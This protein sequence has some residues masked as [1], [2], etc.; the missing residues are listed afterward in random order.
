MVECSTLS[1]IGTFATQLSR[2]KWNFLAQCAPLFVSRL[3][4]RSHHQ[5]HAVGAL[6]SWP[7]SLR[8]THTQ[9]GIRLVLAFRDAFSQSKPERYP[10]DIIHRMN[11][12]ARQSRQ[13]PAECS[14]TDR[15]RFAI[16]RDPRLSDDAPA[17]LHNLTFHQVSVQPAVSSACRYISLPFH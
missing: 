10:L 15:R 13:S 17:A 9:L 2:N 4:S 8:H 16:G 6:S 7:P 5:Q 12:A 11:P 3:D 1:A 14:L